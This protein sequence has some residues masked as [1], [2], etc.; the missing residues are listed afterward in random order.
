M[1]EKEI[2]K[3][4]LRIDALDDELLRLLDR[5]AAAVRKVGGLKGG[6]RVYRPVF[7]LRE[8]AGR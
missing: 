8:T 7:D 4:R 6:R 2:K 3:L 5:R 1:S